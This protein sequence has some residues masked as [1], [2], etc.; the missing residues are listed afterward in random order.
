M[1]P[2]RNESRI[3]SPSTTKV[4]PLKVKLKR[5]ETRKKRKRKRRIRASKLSWTATTRWQ[6]TW[7]SN[8]MEE[9][10]RKAMERM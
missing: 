9:R 4:N 10:K 5:L 3:A 2:S 8:K 6:S 1:Q 7:P